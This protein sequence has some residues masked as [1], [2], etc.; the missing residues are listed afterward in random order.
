MAGT[1][2]LSLLQ[3]ISISVSAGSAP[4]AANVA[5]S[6]PESAFHPR[7]IVSNFSKLPSAAGIVP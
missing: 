7:E 3:R 4:V 6:E 2:P 5:G 1:S